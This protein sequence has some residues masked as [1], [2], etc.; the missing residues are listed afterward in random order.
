M[1]YDTWWGG[2]TFSQK[3]SFPAL[4]VWDGQCLKDSEQKV[5]QGL[6]YPRGTKRYL[7]I[8]EVARIQGIQDAPKGTQG[9][10]RS[11]KY[12]KVQEVPKGPRG[13]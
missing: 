6:M 2:W 11:K 7:N 12:L 8:Q 13:T 10:R 3:F 9:T 4:T 1:T 5:P